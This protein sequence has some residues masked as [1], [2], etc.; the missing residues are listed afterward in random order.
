MTGRLIYTTVFLCTLIL[1]DTGGLD[2]EQPA[3][4]GV[5]INKGED[6]SLI[7]A[8]GEPFRAR[9]VFYYQSRAS[10][11]YFLEGLDI[12]R[13]DSDL[14]LLS[15]TGF[16]TVGLGL[17]WGE[18]VRHADPKD[19]FKPVEYNQENIRKLRLLLNAVKK[20]QMFVYI[21]VGYEKVPPE[22]PAKRYEAVSDNSG[23]EIE[24]FRGYLI[25]DFLL[26][27]AVNSG[28]L[29]YLRLLAKTAAAYDNII[30]YAFY[31]EM[32][33]P[34]MPYAYDWP[35]LN[36]NWRRYL[37]DRNPEVDYWNRRWNTEYKDISRIPLP[38]H[39]RDYWKRWYESRGAEPHESHP[40]MWRDFYDY[41]IG[42]ILTEGRYGMSFEQMS[43]AIKSA[44]PGALTLFKPFYPK[45]WAWELGFVEEYVK[46]GSIPDDARRAFDRYFTP[47][48]IDMIACWA[49]PDFSRDSIEMAR[50]LSFDI[51]A[52]KIDLLFG[53]SSLPVFCQEFGIDHHQWNE[54]ECSLFL[55][56]AIKYFNS[57]P[58]LGYNIWQS[59]DFIEH[60]HTDQIQ[61]NFGIFDIN[62]NP[63]KAVEKITELQT[64]NKTL[65]SEK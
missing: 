20:H 40:L 16:N 28:F 7:N 34:Q 23:R 43:D 35:I 6:I 27:P 38:L 58:V 60:P 65:P 3:Q 45:R 62:G 49:Y 54:D 2:F 29:D 59:H 42:G 53:V 50:Q 14:E 33:N 57:N 56:N 37:N 13:V 46:D 47:P 17:N 11:F 4:K 12:D 44:D 24:E 41:Y 15:K 30:G 31:F 25:E 39:N 1:A 36:S 55:A 22:V 19:S 52:E 5:T 9:G 51:F 18:L 63:C 21:L 10:H 64:E 48:G 61:P 8:A 26:D 32:L